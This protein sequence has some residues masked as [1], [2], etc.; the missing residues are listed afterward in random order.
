MLG[1]LLRLLVRIPVRWV[2]SLMLLA[3]LG[4]AGAMV[5]DDVVGGGLLTP[6]TFT[7]EVVQPVGPGD[8]RRRYLPQ[9]LPTRPGERPAGPLVLPGTMDELA[10][11]WDQDERFGRILLISGPITPAASDAFQTALM[12]QTPPDTIALHSPGGVVTEA[13]R[14][15]RLIR[16]AGFDTLITAD[17]VCNSACPFILFGGEARLVSAEGWVGLHQA[18]LDRNSILTA[19]ET[20]ITVQALQAKV[21]GYIDEMG[22]DP[23][24]M[25]HALA[26]PP[27]QIYYLVPEELQRYS[28]ATEILNR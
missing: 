13:L 8:Q 23:L 17:A 14:I 16:E 11:T 5:Y 3:Q 7:T 18:F 15:G 20:A 28:A 10:F 25:T 26:T 9:I 1:W 2:M 24:V 27:D 4:M 22:I 12:G 21:I 6:N 19:R